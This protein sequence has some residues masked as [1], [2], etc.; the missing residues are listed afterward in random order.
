M[1][2]ITILEDLDRIYKILT[3]KPDEEL[4]NKWR[5]DMK[6]KYYKNQPKCPECLGRGWVNGDGMSE[7][8]ITC[9][10]TGKD[11]YWTPSNE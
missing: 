11:F 4:I 7:S 9:E 5:N 2:K 3:H 1:K 10:G 8:C 6:I